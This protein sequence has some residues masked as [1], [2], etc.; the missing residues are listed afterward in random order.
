MPVYSLPLS[1][2][3]L[4]LKS[5]RQGLD[6]AGVRRSQQQ[7]GRN[8]LQPT[9]R[10]GAL[11]IFLRQFT[12]PLTVVL[13][14]AALFSLLLAEP[15][16]AVVIAAVIAVNVFVGF[17]QEWKAEEA[18]RELAAIT[19]V[20]ARIRRRGGKRGHGSARVVPSDQVVVGDILLLDAGE[21]VAA[22]A[23]IIE[24]R[25]FQVS[26]SVLT[27]ESLP[28]DKAAGTLRRHV[29]LPERSNMVFSGTHVTRGTATAVVTAVGSRSEFGR[30]AEL[31]ATTREQRTPL[32][33]ELGRVARVLALVFIE[34]SFLLFVF[35]V[36]QGRS[37][38]EMA[39]IAVAVSIAAIPEGLL[40][41]LTVIL[42]LGMKRLLGRGAFV[43]RLVATEA[44]GAVSVVATDKTGTLTEGRMATAS[45]AQLAE[46]WQMPADH[47]RVADAPEWVRSV[48]ASGVL[49]SHVRWI[50]ALGKTR[51]APHGDAVEL[52]LVEGV[53]R[54]GSEAAAFEAVPRIDELPFDTERKLMAVLRQPSKGTR[55]LFVKGAPERVLK[56]CVSL[57][58]H[59]GIEPLTLER[60]LELEGLLKHLLSED[61]RVLGVAEASVERKFTGQLQW[62]HVRD[63]TFVGFIAFADPI[64]REVPEAVVTTQR[65]GVRTLML[66][67]DHALTAERV[68][69][70]IGMNKAGSAVI[71]GT[72]L[73]AMD[74]A[75]LRAFL[76][77]ESIFARVEPLQKLRIVE[78][79]HANGEVVAMIGDGVND[80]PA[81]KM[82]DVGVAVGSGSDV[83]KEVADLVLLD[84]SFSTFTAAIREGRV[85]LANIRKVLLF[86]LVDSFSELI[87]I[88]S[89]LIMG[90]PV[91]LLPLQIL[92]IN[93]IADGFPY[94]AL[95]V[96]KEEPGA[97]REPPRRR[98]EPLLNREL[99]TII[100][101]MA[102]ITNAAL[103]LFY[104]WFSQHGVDV[105][106]LR[107]V[108]FAVLGI[109][110]LFY[111]FAC[112]SL[113][114]PL[115]KV[116]PF[117]NP[118]LLVAVFFGMTLQIFAV[119]SPL[120]QEI[121]GTTALSFG[122]WVFVFSI[123]ISNLLFIELFK[124]VVRW[125]PKREERM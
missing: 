91:P 55:T 86:L 71:D 41:G 117:S 110:S 30:I 64:R 96:E 36:V 3:F 83:A 57:K 1:G 5:D 40:V 77:R 70:S 10:F 93:M 22:D 11:G 8:V 67:G 119:Q 9:A 45:V 12:S 44:L 43:R 38:V 97:M 123:A 120:L 125:Y 88:G 58:H 121:L 115:W 89:A 92:W 46:V 48:L 42:V 61:L 25:N 52:A 75:E 106:V 47:A 72:A 56:R 59:R 16:D 103:L 39:R 79:L 99:K 78:A 35:G 66:T 73:Q 101:G 63:L 62:E 98:D 82:A 76:K 122:E 23:R 14:I 109:A 31:T 50:E 13:I 111:V 85:I 34:L 24:A 49:A 21:V 118:L 37:W 65:A 102:L 53:E 2:L 105:T 112:R 32:Q 15:V 74:D 17:T 124:V 27:G 18:F 7:W 80:A 90:L 87:L 81:L 29:A 68:A 19:V 54:L 26:E 100:A 116:S 84:D 107:T 114:Q 6:P 28:V 4:S 20:N 113:S 95:T 94:L 108:V 51:L 60:Q 69:L 33:H 104:V